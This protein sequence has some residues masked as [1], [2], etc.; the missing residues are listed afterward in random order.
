MEVIGQLHP[1]VALPPLR[2][3]LNKKSGG[4][5]SRSGSNGR[6]KN[7]LHLWAIK[8]WRL[9]LTAVAHNTVTV[10]FFRYI[11]MSNYWIQWKYN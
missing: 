8:R 4:P 7:L 6:E 1:S 5:H 9:C 11:I 3:A 10:P 2:Y